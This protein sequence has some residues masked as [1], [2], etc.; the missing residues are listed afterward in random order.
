MLQKLNL[1][2]ILTR[3]LT[4]DVLTYFFIISENML[5]PDWHRSSYLLHRSPMLSLLSHGTLDLEKIHHLCQK[6]APNQIH[7]YWTESNLYAITLNVILICW[8][9]IW[10]SKKAISKFKKLISVIK[11]PNGKVEMLQYWLIY[12]ISNREIEYST[13]R[14]FDRVQ[15]RSLNINMSYTINI[16]TSSKHLSDFK[17]LSLKHSNN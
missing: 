13:L 11:K 8:Q 2:A 6:A 12:N 3:V 14:S 10:H 9:T 4:K 17:R 15:N 16:K 7:T 5:G 1:A